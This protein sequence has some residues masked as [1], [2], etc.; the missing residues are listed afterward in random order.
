MNIEIKATEKGWQTVKVARVESPTSPQT[1]KVRLASTS[2][3]HYGKG[4]S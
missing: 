3:S 4:W 2:S 1:P